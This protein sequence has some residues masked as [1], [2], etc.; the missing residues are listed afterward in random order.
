MYGTVVGRTK[1]DLPVGSL[2]TTQNTVHESSYFGK[3]TENYQ[4]NPPSISR[5]QGRTFMGF[6]REDGQVG[7]ANYWLI[8]PLVF[9]ENRNVEV[10]KDAFNDALGY[11]KINP[12]KSMVKNM[13]PW[14]DKAC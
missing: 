5:F 3:K 12:F 11:G 4:W 14:L 2:I 8:I 10:I 6:H 9:C 7:T 13:F 1:I